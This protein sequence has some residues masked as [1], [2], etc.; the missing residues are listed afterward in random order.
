M[1][2]SKFQPIC[3][4]QEEIARKFC[5][6]QSREED[7]KL[8]SATQNAVGYALSWLLDPSPG[9]SDEVSKLTIKE[10]FTTC[11][12]KFCSI[13]GAPIGRLVDDNLRRERAMLAQVETKTKVPFANRDGKP[14]RSDGSAPKFAKI[15][16][17]LSL[18]QREMA[19]LK[20]QLHQAK[21]NIAK[22]RAE[23]SF[24]GKKDSQED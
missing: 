22:E 7:A 8:N 9:D 11:R 10:V 4:L 23:L 2:L 1:E 16:K 18:A 12:E 6:F 19:K 14:D 17:E 24:K 15:N 3:S 13:N 5:R 21:E 20:N